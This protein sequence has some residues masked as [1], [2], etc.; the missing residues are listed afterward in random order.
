MLKHKFNAKAC[1]ADNI[2]F[3]SKAERSY[4]HK[5][6]ILKESGQILFFLMQVPF[7]LPGNIIYRIDF[8]EFW[9]PK[10]DQ[11]GDIIFTEVKGVM[12]DSARIKI[13]QTQELYNIHINVVK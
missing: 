1:E 8:V 2:K 4:Y 5:L 6:K 9:A 11:P 3:S 13:L 7:R 10:H 12:T